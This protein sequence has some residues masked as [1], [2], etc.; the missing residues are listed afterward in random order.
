MATDYR[1]S[2]YCIGGDYRAPDAAKNN[3]VWTTDNGAS[4]KAPD[5]APPYGYR[6]CI[7][8]IWNKRLVAC[9]P[10][11]VDICRNPNEWK[12]ISGEGFNVCM[13]SP[14]K[15]LIFFGGEKGRIGLLN[16]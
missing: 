13:I 7:S 3:L 14:N 16:L 4:W 12:R 15:K 6:S 10:N 9:G 1:E 11:G 8:V 2:F 5:G